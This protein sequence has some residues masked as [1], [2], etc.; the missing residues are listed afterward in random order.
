MRGK[1]IV[2]L[3]LGIILSIVNYS[4][5]QPVKE[6]ICSAGSLMPPVS[7]LQV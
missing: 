7:R 6:V 1:W 3:Y 5:A 4:I 2:V